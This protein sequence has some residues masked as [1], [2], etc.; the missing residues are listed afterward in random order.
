MSRNSRT[1]ETR[2]DWK[3][4]EYGVLELVR[5]WWP[6]A[7]IGGGF[8]VIAGA[9]LIAQLIRFFGLR[10]D[11]LAREWKEVLGPFI[12]LGVFGPVAVLLLSFL[13][14]TW[15]DGRREHRL[16]EKYPGQPWRHRSDWASGRSD[17][18]LTSRAFAYAGIALSV[19]TLTVG[20]AIL[21]ML[22]RNAAESTIEKFGLA[23]V[24]AGFIV[25]AVAGGI[26]ALSVARDAV[27]FRRVTCELVGLPFQPGQVFRCLVHWRQAQPLDVPLFIILECDALRSTRAKVFGKE[28]GESNSY[29]HTHYYSM[30]RFITGA[31]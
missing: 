6:I 16:Q 23:L 2:A 15:R 17:H 8:A 28:V 30:T 24:F 4:D 7:V 1:T 25:F 27:R 11:V 31:G 13:W 9:V 5:Q 14:V 3:A 19:I 20:G 10:A 29:Q 12:V 22:D 21:F 26:Y 18:L